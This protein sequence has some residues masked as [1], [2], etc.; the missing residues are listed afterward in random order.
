MTHSKVT[1]WLLSVTRSS[2]HSGKRKQ[3]GALGECEWERDQPG[4]AGKGIDRHRETFNSRFLWSRKWK[5]TFVY[6][7]IVPWLLSVQSL[8]WNKCDGGINLM[9]ESAFQCI[10][11]RIHHGRNS[12]YQP[13]MKS[14][15]IRSWNLAS[16]ARDSQHGC[17]SISTIFSNQL[18]YL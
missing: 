12:N 3:A 11:E 2:E 15:W 14:S 16:W 7:G 4:T 8:G 1:Q 13:K 10:Y 9:R 18:D 5:W 17:Y 6:L